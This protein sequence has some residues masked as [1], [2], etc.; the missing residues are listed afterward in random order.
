MKK[1]Q[2][3]DLDLFASYYRIY[4]PIGKDRRPHEI[5]IF[6][7]EDTAK[8]FVGFFP[9]KDNSY[10]QIHSVV[11]ITD[12]GIKFYGDKTLKKEIELYL[13]RNIVDLHKTFYF[14]PIN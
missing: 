9:D 12:S 2:K 8:E 13:S 11:A 10:L 1:F 14:L 3:M 5:S 7:S 4:I 6:E